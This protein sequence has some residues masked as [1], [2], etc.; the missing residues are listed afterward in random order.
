MY[1]KPTREARRQS[2]SQFDETV[3]TAAADLIARGTKPTVRAVVSELEDAPFTKTAGALRRFWRAT[4]HKIV[5]IA[6]RLAAVDEEPGD[7]RIAIAKGLSPARFVTID[8]GGVLL[9]VTMSSLISALEA[10][11]SVHHAA[12]AD[13]GG[14]V[15][16]LPAATPV[17]VRLTAEEFTFLSVRA[18]ILN[19]T[20]P[21]QESR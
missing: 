2:L 18:A 8:I 20:E 12:D 7:H 15:V 14:I 5:G 9:Q 19:T 1:E 16:F 10:H 4:L 3:A 17:A 11:D 13:G 6:P 21:V